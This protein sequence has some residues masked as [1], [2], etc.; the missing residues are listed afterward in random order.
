M[1]KSGECWHCL[2]KQRAWVSPA[3]LKLNLS[4]W[5]QLILKS[6]LHRQDNA[7]V[8]E[9]MMMSSSLYYWI[10]GLICYKLDLMLEARRLLRL[11]LPNIQ[12]HNS[13]NKAR[14]CEAVTER[15]I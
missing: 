15:Q 3:V 9:M 2:G 5:L 11:S 14:V 1:A 6:L 10:N 13:R 7:V 8:E 12:P 4:Q